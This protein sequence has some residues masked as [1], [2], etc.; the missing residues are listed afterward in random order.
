MKSLYSLLLLVAILCHAHSF[1]SESPQDLNDNTVNSP[2]VGIWQQYD[3]HEEIDNRYYFEY[4]G[5]GEFL[6]IKLSDNSDHPEY[7]SKRYGVYTIDGNILTM[8]YRGNEPE[9]QDIH[10]DNNNNI[11]IINYPADESRQPMTIVYRRVPQSEYNER[12]KYVK[13]WSY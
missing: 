4:T 8:N 1:A 13:T 10:F 9:I 6:K 12:V 3:P 11:L 2:I 5:S 7:G